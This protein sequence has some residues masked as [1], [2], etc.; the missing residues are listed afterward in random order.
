[1]VPQVPMEFKGTK[2]WQNKE[3]KEKMADKENFGLAALGDL[4]RGFLG[5]RPKAAM[6]A[7]NLFATP[8]IT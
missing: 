4:G 2:R 6:K 8:Y 5:F 1:M 7:V 3:N